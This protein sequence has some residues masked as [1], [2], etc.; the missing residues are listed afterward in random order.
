MRMLFGAMIALTLAV[1]GVS[2][3]QEKGAPKPNIVFILADDCGYGDFGFTGHPYVKTPAIDRFAT[4]GAFF[5]NFYVSGP[6][7]SPSRTGLMTG[8]FPATFEKIPSSHGFS[9]ATTITELLKR[10]GYRTA[11]FGKWHI[12]PNTAAGT[13]GI[14]QI[15]EIHNNRKDPRGRDTDITD[16]VIQFL[17]AQKKE[18]PFYVNVWYHTVHNPVNPPQAFVDRFKDLKVNLADFANPDFLRDINEYQKA[19]EDIHAGMR[20]HVADMAQLDEQVARLL[21]T[22]DDLG[23][24]DSTI[25]VFSSDNGPHGYGSAGVFR[26]KK[27]SLYDGGVHVPMLVRWPGHVKAGRVDGTSVLAGVDWL[28]TLSRI[29]GI[30]IDPDKFGGEDVSD[31]WLGKERPRGKDLFWRTFGGPKAT[32]VILRGSWKLH[33]NPKAP[34]E[35]YNLARDPGQRTNVAAQHPDVVRELT[36]S[37]NRWTATLPKKYIGEDKE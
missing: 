36:T 32:P 10:I 14:D 35:L 6:V 37:L 21:K 19:G 27:H 12:G 9:G 33:Q 20:K 16:A 29:A 7:C 24:T 11:H 23:L 1:P 5:K 25:V 4:Q 13:Y 18:Q 28:P 26:E 2:V 34:T 15:K 31:I 17:R 8:R 30:K 3:G 22:I